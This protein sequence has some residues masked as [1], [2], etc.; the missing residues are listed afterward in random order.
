MDEGRK[1]RSRDKADRQ[2]RGCGICCT[3]MERERVT[4]FH[5][6]SSSSVLAGRQRVNLQLKGQSLFLIVDIVHTLSCFYQYLKVVWTLK[7]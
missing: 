6:L 5:S 2:S 7:G 1:K 4:V 3:G